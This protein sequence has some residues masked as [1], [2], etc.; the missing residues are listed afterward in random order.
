M[1]VVLIQLMMNLKKHSALSE[2]Y[3]C[4][5]GILYGLYTEMVEWRWTT[6]LVQYLLME[7]K[8]LVFQQSGQ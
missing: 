6:L 5:L 3:Y 4:E 2:Y 8:S 1:L 7:C